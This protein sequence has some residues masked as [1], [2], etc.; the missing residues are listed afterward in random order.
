MRPLQPLRV[1]NAVLASSRSLPAKVR[2]IYVLLVPT[3]RLDPRHV[4]LVGRGTSLLQVL[5]N[6]VPVHMVRAVM[7]PKRSATLVFLELSLCL[8]Q[9]N[10]L[11]V[12]LVCIRRSSVPRPVAIAHQVKS[13]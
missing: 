3:V 12:Q 5:R 11:N 9:I 13:R 4:S 6:A 8:L 7:L 1:P 10:A 2:V